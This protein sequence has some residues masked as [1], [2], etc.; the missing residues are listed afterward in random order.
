MATKNELLAL[1]KDCNFSRDFHGRADW[2]N[3]HFSEDQ[4]GPSAIFDGKLGRV[5][6]HL[7][8]VTKITNT[9]LHCF[10]F[11]AGERVTY[12]IPLEGITIQN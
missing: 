5:C 4:K 7:G 9:H 8:N 6:D 3:F 11:L 2:F 1:T 10:K 12:R